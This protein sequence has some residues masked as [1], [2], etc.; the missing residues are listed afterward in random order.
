MFEIYKNLLIPYKLGFNKIRIGKNYDGGYILAKELLENCECVYSLGVGNECS[1]DYQLAE[2]GL[3]IYM[4]DGSVENPPV[5]NKN[6]I[7]NKKYINHNNF[8]EELIKN[9][10]FNNKNMI[11]QI[12]I[13]GNEYEFFKNL[14]EEVLLKFSQI[15]VEFHELHFQYLKNNDWI[16]KILNNFYIFH[17]HGNNIGMD[18]REGRGYIGTYVDGFPN[19]LEVSF[20]RKDLVTQQT[21]IDNTSYPL[22]GLDYP[23]AYDKKDYE[24]NWWVK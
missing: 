10:H 11:A 14:D 18:G 16:N 22:S 8:V 9:N 24:L 17:M 19:V 3:K 4:Y 15:C 21:V 23:N 13:E 7:F 1:F 6:F 2:M 20:V 12:D 5:S